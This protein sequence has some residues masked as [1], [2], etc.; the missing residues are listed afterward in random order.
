MFR[1]CEVWNVRVYVSDHFSAHHAFG[2][3]SAASRG[4]C[5]VY[6]V[7]DAPSQPGQIRGAFAVRP[8]PEIRSTEH[9]HTHS[10][11]RHMYRFV[12]SQ[13][14]GIGSSLAIESARGGIISCRTRA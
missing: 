14:T 4:R 11:V 5:Y 7:C 8:S 2:A 9:S 3:T 6:T 12:V 13:R 1:A 10:A